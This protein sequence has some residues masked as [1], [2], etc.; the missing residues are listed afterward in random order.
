MAYIHFPFIEYGNV[1]TITWAV[2]TAGVES[3]HVIWWTA[4][5]IEY[6]QI[7]F[8]TFPNSRVIVFK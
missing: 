5:S 4:V 3:R 1:S 7:C 6:V 2:T 8:I